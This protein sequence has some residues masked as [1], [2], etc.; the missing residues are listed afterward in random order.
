MCIHPREL[1][2][3]VHAL[4]DNIIDNLK[5]FKKREVQAGRGWKEE[6]GETQKMCHIDGEMGVIT[7]SKNKNVSSISSRKV[8]MMIEMN[9]NHV[10]V[11]QWGWGEEPKP[12]RDLTLRQWGTNPRSLTCQ[13]PAAHLGLPQ[14]SG[15]HSCSILRSLWLITPSKMVQACALLVGFGYG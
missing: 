8:V 4:L 9:P 13:V 3:W 10:K 7:K 6:G 15:I 1:Q 11:F 5:N 2:K 12:K 14:V